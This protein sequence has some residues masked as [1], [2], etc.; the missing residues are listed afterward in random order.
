M[1]RA[2]VLVVCAV[3]ALLTAACSP[4]SSS[5]A[6][7]FVPS[8]GG[9]PSEGPGV[10]I[11]P[12]VPL[13]PAPSGNG[14]GAPSTGGPSGS[15]SPS[16]KPAIDPRV[17][18]TRLSAP[19]GL[20]MMP[21]GTALVGERAGRIVR[22]QP[23]AGKPVP[24]VR[25]ITG[26]NTAGDGGL[27]D[28]A[29]SPEYRQDSLIYAYVTTARD[30]RVVDFT[31]NGPV[32][33]VLTGIPRGASGNAGRIAFG[34][35]GDLY[36][37]TGDAGRPANAEN[38]KSLAG[39]VLRVNSIGAPD[40]TNPRPASP[41]FTSGHQTGAGLCA[42]EQSNAVLE[43]EPG[44]SGAAAEVNDLVAGGS[45]GWPKAGS[46]DRSPIASLPRSTPVP[47][48]CAITKGRLWV[49]SLNA[50][51]LLDAPVAVGADS[52]DVGKFS[53]LLSRKYGRLKTIV[54]AKD[55]ALWMTTSNR[56]GKGKPVAVDERVIRYVPSNSASKP[57]SPV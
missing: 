4:A 49:T 16:A 30:N 48:D 55:G 11:S 41:V 33:P 42:L 43:V 25:T 44:A 5:D 1:R 50:Q 15:S 52:V 2:S 21:D 36:V 28:L 45:Y 24:T 31:L 23:V 13:P 37:S 29:L 47:G 19:I 40:S 39:K 53:T 3:C 20:T 7:T 27:L 12:I 34:A 22:V 26:L 51:A 9:L 32:T 10:Q 38:P 54:A 18:A 35:D 56:D 8:P 57:N 17:V 6:P 46:A 14:E